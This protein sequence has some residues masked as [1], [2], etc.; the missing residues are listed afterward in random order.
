MSIVK[1]TPFNTA[2]DLP[3]T[4][5]GKDHRELALRLKQAGLAWNPHVG[6][7]VWDP[8]ESIPA[9]SP[10]P[11][12]VYFILNRAHF[13]RFLGTA[14]RMKEKLVWLPTWHQARLMARMIG[15]G[16]S[17]LW[18][19]WSENAVP[20]P[21]NDLLRLYELLLARLEKK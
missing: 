16:E 2:S 3:P 18:G 1:P 9:D 6:C 13:L 7:F 19:L 17:E 14:D 11:D 21:G 15:I 4:P 20:A 12:R 8:Q 5:F 10:F